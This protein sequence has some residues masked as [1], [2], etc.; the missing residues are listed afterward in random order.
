MIRNWAK[1]HAE[2]TRILTLFEKAT[3]PRNRER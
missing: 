3:Q 1:K 2:K